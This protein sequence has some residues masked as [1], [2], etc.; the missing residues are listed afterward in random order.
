MMKCNT[1]GQ[2]FDPGNLTSVMIHEHNEDINP[3][4]AIGIK[5][6]RMPKKME[7]KGDDVTLLKV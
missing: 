1:C 4:L 5:G 3:A 2:E 7:I 6:E